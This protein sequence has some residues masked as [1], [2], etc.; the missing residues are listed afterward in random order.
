MASFTLTRTREC[1]SQNHVTISVT[2]DVTYTFDGDM[3]DLTGPVTEDEKE[4][5]LKVLLRVAK[6]GRTRTQIRNALTN[7]YTITI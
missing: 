5:F 4:A 3:A 7:G 1:G 6:I 2:G